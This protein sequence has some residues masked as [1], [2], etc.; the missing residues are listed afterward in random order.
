M[1]LPKSFLLHFLPLGF[2]SRMLWC[3]ESISMLSEFKGNSLVVSL[4]YSGRPMKNCWFSVCSAFS[5]CMNIRDH[6]KL[7]SCSNRNQKSVWIHLFT[8]SKTA[9]WR[10]FALCLIYKFENW[11]EIECLPANK[12]LLIIVIHNKVEIY[13]PDSKFRVLYSKTSFLTP[14]C[15]IT[16]C[17]SFELPG[18]QF[19]H[20]WNI[21][22]L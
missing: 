12:N 10:L 19:F 8:V 14:P 11:V 6:F 16:L 18:S 4:Q 21:N 1:G 20:V 17:K 15:H 2:Y 13:V 3:L 9:S 22:K 5:C 7:L